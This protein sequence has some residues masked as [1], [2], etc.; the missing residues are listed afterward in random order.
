M[1]CALLLH[2]DVVFD[3]GNAKPSDAL[4]PEP[5]LPIAIAAQRWRDLVYVHW[6][7]D[8][9]VIRPHLPPGLVLDLLPDRRAVVSLV[10]FLTEG[11]RPRLVPRVFGLSFPEVNVRTYVR[12]PA[13]GRGVFFLSLDAASLL[14]AV[15]GRAMLGLP[16]HRAYVEHMRIGSAIRYRGYRLDGSAVPAR[17]FSLAIEE[18]SE[19]AVAGEPG[20]FEHFVHERYAMYWRGK[21]GLRSISIRH[22]PLPVVRASIT[23]LHETLTRSAAI[24]VHRSFPAAYVCRS[25]DVAFYPPESVGVHSSAALPRIALAR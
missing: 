14:F 22:A 25:M 2:G 12:A 18:R 11:A 16:Y 17:H 6:N 4:A 7:V 1:A 13:H 21:R 20:S 8:P 19:P 10:T 23:D 9:D 3:T 5:R 24:D 15:S